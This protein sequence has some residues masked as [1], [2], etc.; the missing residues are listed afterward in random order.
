MSMWS[1]SAV[2]TRKE[3]LATQQDCSMLSL[4]SLFS[5]LILE[6]LDSLEGLLDPVSLAAMLGNI[7]D[8]LC[9]AIWKD[10]LLTV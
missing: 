9:P 10:L 5:R 7:W 3:S 6:C 1:V 2:W 8:H 4:T